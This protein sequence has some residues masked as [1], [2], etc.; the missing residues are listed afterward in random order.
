MIRERE[1]DKGRA[2]KNSVLIG[3]G[4]LLQTTRFISEVQQSC[5]AHLSMSRPARPW[6]NGKCESFLKTLKRK[7]S[8]PAATAALR[9]SSSIWRSL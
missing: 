9:N 2:V 6:E 8:T 3:S 4:S 5:A 1:R 7:K